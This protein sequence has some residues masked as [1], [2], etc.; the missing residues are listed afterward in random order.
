MSDEERQ[1]MCCRQV[2]NVKLMHSIFTYSKPLEDR[3]VPK[4]DLAWIVN[5]LGRKSRQYLQPYYITA[6]TLPLGDLFSEIFEDDYYVMIT[7]QAMQ[8]KSWT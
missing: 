3:L 5:F 4:F 2:E 8:S 1:D 6:L 7:R